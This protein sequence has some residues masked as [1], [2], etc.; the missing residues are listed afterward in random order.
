METAQACLSAAHRSLLA[1]EAL[2]AL[3]RY[4]CGLARLAACDV[5]ARTALLDAAEARLQ[6][7]PGPKRT[8]ETY[9]WTLRLIDLA[10]R[11]ATAGP[12]ATAAR[13]PTALI[14]AGSAG[15][16]EAQAIQALGLVPLFTQ[17]L[18][19]FTGT[20]LSGGTRCGIPGCAG[21][22]AEA[23]GAA[24]AFRLIGYLPDNLPDHVRSDSR[25][26]RLVQSGARFSPDQVLL[27]WEDL[28][29]AGT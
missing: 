19:G 28:F 26:D 13:H 10:R 25:Y 9:V 22:A 6:D 16:L 1:D 21:A 27:Y 17:A 8:S 20:V 23:L 2:E 4:A 14:L 7:V 3:T 11:A 5:R 24:R 18:A 29:A 12:A 15:S